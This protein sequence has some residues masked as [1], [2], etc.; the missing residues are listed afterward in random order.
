MAADFILY[1]TTTAKEANMACGDWFCLGIREANP[2]GVFFFQDKCWAFEA[3]PGPEFILHAFL[4][5]VWPSEAQ[6]R[7]SKWSRQPTASQQGWNLWS[8]SSDQWDLAGCNCT[9]TRTVFA[10]GGGT[11]RL[12]CA[13]W[14]VRLS[15]E[16]EAANSKNI[17]MAKKTDAISGF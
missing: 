5:R 11:F 7:T 14:S 3:L 1:F 13:L 9:A 17:R 4:V 6:T 16:P 2:S 8:K 15:L 12:S 10:E